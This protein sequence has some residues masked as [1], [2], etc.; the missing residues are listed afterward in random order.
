M[1]IPK[2]DHDQLKLILEV[3]MNPDMKIFSQLEP[4]DKDTPAQQCVLGK[5]KKDVDHLVE[6]G[7]LKNITEVHKEQVAQILEQSGNVYR[8]FEVTA[9]AQA[10][11]QA[12]T[13]PVA[14]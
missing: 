8:I 3:V 12:Y 14:N 13:S 1:E 4:S 2:I 5:G 10:V 9:L 11:F 6:L 7:L